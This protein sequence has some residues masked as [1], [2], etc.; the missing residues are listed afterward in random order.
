MTQSTGD[1]VRIWSG[2][3]GS[4]T[5]VL[6]NFSSNYSNQKAFDGQCLKCHRDGTGEGIG[7]TK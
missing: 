5:D 7:L 4:S 1:R 2:Y 6:I 3:A